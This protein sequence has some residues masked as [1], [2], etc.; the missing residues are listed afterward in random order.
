MCCQLSLWCHNRSGANPI[1]WARQPYLNWYAVTNICHVANKSHAPSANLLHLGQELHHAVQAH[2]VQGAETF[3]NKHNVWRHLH[4][5]E[6][7]SYESHS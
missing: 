2:G 3:V 7:G 5:A 6:K 4:N 1:S